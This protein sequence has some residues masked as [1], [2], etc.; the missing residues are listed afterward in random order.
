MVTVLVKHDANWLAPSPL[1]Q[2]ENI[3]ATAPL[4]GRV[5]R[6]AI[7]RFQNDLFMEELLA[8]TAYQPDR[9]QEWIARPETW[10]DP[11]PAPPTTAQLRV[12]DPISKRSRRIAR[13][14]ARLKGSNDNESTLDAPSS[15]GS[16]GDGL[17]FKLYQPA[18]QRFYLVAAALVCQRPGYPDRAVDP[19][20]QEQVGFV[21]RRLVPDSTE[22]D[23]ACDP[24]NP[25]CREYAFINTPGGYAW[26]EVGDSDRQTIL[27]GEERLPLFALN[28]DETSYRRRLLA[29]LIPVG[30]RETY[31]AAPLSDDAQIGSNASNGTTPQ[32]DPRRMLLEADVIAPWKALVEQ[33]ETVKSRLL[34]IAK[35]PPEETDNSTVKDNFEKVII[36]SR[37]QIQTASWYILFDFAKFLDAHI[38]G[39]YKNIMGQ[40][41]GRPLTGAETTLVSKIAGITI[42]TGTALYDSLDDP[43]YADA[44]YEV[45]TS[46][47]GALR[48]I[49]TLEGDLEDVD[50]PLDL[51]SDPLAAANKWPDFLFPLANP[52]VELDDGLLV[53]SVSAA[54]ELAAPSPDVT[55]DTTDLTAVEI[56]LAKIDAFADLVEDALDK[57]TKPLPEIEMPPAPWDTRDA[58]FVI[59]CVYERPNCGPINPEV[60]SQPTQPFQMAPFFDPDAPARPIRIPMPIDISPA[61]LRKFKNNA[62][63]MISDM[64]CGKIKGIKKLSLGDLVLSVLPWPFHKDLPNIGNTGPCKKGETNFGMFC[65][66]SIP[67][68]TLCALILL[69]IIVALFDTFFRWLPYLFICF[70]IQGLK[71]KKDD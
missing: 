51:A 22:D 8:L 11:M 34:D 30:K 17:P 10:R 20:N 23:G 39:V 37:E 15:G 69:L 63:F 26:K 45:K 70:P 18:Q 21:I 52:A 60:V 9:L 5:D 2:Q 57:P 53:F 4:N 48:A 64:L 46:L 27:T 55:V 42:G 13:E 16:N 50:F 41:L 36:A 28:F 62:T 43:T 24:D 38:N 71:G 47:A 33:A 59:R 67:I 3:E 14:T 56:T 61:G 54:P 58:W 31:L 44:S 6:P 19:G 65:S 49:V 7:L 66:L 25:D 12:V 32:P 35:P 40:P 68:V 29:G 1:W